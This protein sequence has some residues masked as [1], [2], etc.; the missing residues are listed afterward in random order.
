MV[1][2]S[3]TDEKQFIR[4]ISSNRFATNIILK[5]NITFNCNFYLDEY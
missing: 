3:L 4:E 1:P 2:Q 5:E